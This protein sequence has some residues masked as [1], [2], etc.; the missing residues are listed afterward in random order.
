MPALRMSV[1]LV[2]MPWM[3]GLAFSC[4]IPALSAPSAKSL[5]FKSFNVLMIQAT[6]NLNDFLIRAR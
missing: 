1:G 3:S 5:T 6:V 4:S 2:V